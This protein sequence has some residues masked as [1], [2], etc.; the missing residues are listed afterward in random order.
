MDLWMPKNLE[1]NVYSNL[2]EGDIWVEGLSQT[3]RISYDPRLDVDYVQNSIRY[4][5]D[6]LPQIQALLAP[7]ILKFCKQQMEDYPD[8]DY[9]D[10]M[11]RIALSSVWDFVAIEE[12]HIDFC[13]PDVRQVK[14]LNLYGS[15]NWEFEDGLQWLIRDGE[16]LYSGPWND[17]HV[18]Q[19]AEQFACGNYK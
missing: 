1:R 3:I 16:V 8:V 12:L 13:E 5:N 6:N 15:C 14:V 9:P 18:W 19:P 4:L 10:G 11:E 2:L 7:S 17:Y